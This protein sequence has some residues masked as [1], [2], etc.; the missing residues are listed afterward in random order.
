LG[1]IDDQPEKESKQGT[2]RKTLN[3][4]KLHIRFINIEIGV[5]GK[6]LRSI[7]DHPEKESKQG[8]IRKI[9][10]WLKLHIK[11][12]KCRNLGFK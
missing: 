6:R 7:H 9:F 3:P 12:I 5:F 4:L 8:T 11:L 2:I 10:S 1:S